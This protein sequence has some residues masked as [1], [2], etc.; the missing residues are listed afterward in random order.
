MANFVDEL[1]KTQYA[2]QQT[3]E[4]VSI[5]DTK[6]NSDKTRATISGELRLKDQSEPAPLTYELQ[7]KWR[8]ENFGLKALRVKDE[9]Q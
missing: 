8:M 2:F 9:Q 4:G 6:Y 7:N 3:V 1:A 5:T